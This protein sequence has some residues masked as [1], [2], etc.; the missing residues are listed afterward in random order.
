MSQCYIHANL[1]KIHS[2]VHDIVQ[3]RKCHANDDA[4]TE[5]NTNGSR[6]K[7]NMSPSPLVGDI[8]SNS[9]L[10]CIPLLLVALL[11]CGFNIPVNSS[12]HVETAS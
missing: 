5:T 6:T 3:T 11:I 2:P 12:G 10:T 1:F 8:I 4:D 7:N 9:Y